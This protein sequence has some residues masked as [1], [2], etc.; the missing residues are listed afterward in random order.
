LGAGGCFTRRLRRLAAKL[1]YPL[2]R[3][4]FG[5]VVYGDAMPGIREM[6]GHRIAHYAEAKKSNVVWD[7]RFVS[8]SGSHDW[9]LS[10]QSG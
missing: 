10:L 5:A 2:L 6:R 3:L 8:F 9:I 4:L 7:S 1:L